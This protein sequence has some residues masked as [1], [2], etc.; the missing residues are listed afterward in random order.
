MAI[1][2]AKLMNELQQAGI[3][4]DGCAS[5]GRIDFKKEATDVQKELA[6]KILA[7]HNPFWYVEE[8]RK[9]YAARPIEDQIDC[10]GK[11]LKFLK[12]NGVNIGVDGDDWVAWRENIK[13]TIPKT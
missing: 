2:I 3:P 5:D 9:L 1:N 11:I 7:N 10:L 6:K 8:R 13:I 4:I 12:A